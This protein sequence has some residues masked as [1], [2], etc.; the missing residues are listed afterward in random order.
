[1]SYLKRPAVQVVTADRGRGKSA[2]LGLLSAALIKQ[3]VAKIT[4]VAPALSAVEALFSAAAENL[5]GM[6]ALNRV[7]CALGEA[8]VRFYQPDRMLEVMPETDVLLVDEAAAIPVPVLG[9]LAGRLFPLCLCFNH[10][11]L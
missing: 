1:M 10:S 9:A 7:R 6:S 8:S 3:G 2:S 11:W 5:V 4:V